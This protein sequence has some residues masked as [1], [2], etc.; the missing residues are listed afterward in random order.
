MQSRVS[1]CSIAIALVGTVAAFASA[2]TPSP[3]GRAH[4][5]GRVADALGNSIPKAEIIVS[6]TALHAESGTD[7]RFEVS[8]LPTGSVE[9]IVRRIGFSPAKIALE[10][11]SGERRDIRVMLSPM[12][13][14]MDSVS[15]TA[16]APTTEVSYGGFET[17]RSRGFG[18]FITREDIEKRRARVPSDLFR[19]MSG[20]KLIRDNGTL[21]VASNRL[22]AMNCPL[23][24]FIDGSHY[25]LYGQSIDALVHIVDIGAIEVY[26]GGATVPPQFSGRESTCGVI[27]IW[28][29]HGQKKQ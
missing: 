20:V 25:P 3:E 16:P 26:A 10:L 7:G 4:L 13:V 27:A 5:T 12:A 6:S 19:T 28:T 9:V 21:T 15:V 8:G 17:R 24:V 22:G 18:T 14:M 2:Q 29:R 1:R 23:R 11:T